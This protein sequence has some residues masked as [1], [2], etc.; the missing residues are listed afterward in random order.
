MAER[1]TG[2]ALAGKVAL[3]TGGSR[4]IGAAIAKRLAHDGADIAISYAA[5][6][7]KAA[8]VV[9]ELEVLGVRAAAFQADQGDAEQVERLVGAV[10][11]RFGRL[12]ILVNN[13]GMFVMGPVDNPANDLAA[14]ARQLAVNVVGVSAAVR[15]AAKVL[16]AGGRIISIGSTVGARVPF[17]GLADYSATKAAVVAYTKGWARDLGLRGITVN[18]VQ[19]GPIDTD[20]N[21]AD[22]EF[23]GFQKAA[24]ALG[25]YGRPEEVAAA[26]AFLASPE[27]SFITGATLDVDGGQNA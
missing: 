11:E 12:D 3:V 18:A 25:R 7:E 26:V 20:M 6:T 14:F 24:T 1:A 23:S 15:A 22:G 16:G 17:V 27:A 2:R 10:A 9:R 19:P 21:P 13:A 5:S 4:G 8:A